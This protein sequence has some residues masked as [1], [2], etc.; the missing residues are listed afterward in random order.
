MKIW[1]NSFTAGQPIPPRCAFCTID[2]DTHVALSDNLSPHLAWSELPDGTLSLAVICVDPD[3]PSSGENVNQEG[4]VVPADLPRVDFFHWAM[5]N[6]SPDLGAIE[7]GAFSTGVTARGKSG[8]LGPM[9]TSHAT[10]NYT[11]WFDGDADMGGDYHGYDGPCP[12]WNDELLHHYHFTVYALDT[13]TI[14]LPDN[15]DALAVKAAIEGHVLASDTI[16]GTY[17][18]NPDV[19]S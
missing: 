11:Q 4:K 7:E 3:G 18:L 15:P 9:G 2:P 16:V 19:A 13:G 10:N 5:V 12:P 6:L 8:P 17:T 1:S 14:T